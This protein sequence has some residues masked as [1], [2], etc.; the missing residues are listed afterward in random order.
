MPVTKTTFLISAILAATIAGSV[1]FALASSQP[2]SD[3]ALAP[4]DVVLTELPGLVP[5]DGEPMLAG[6]ADAAPEKGVVGRIPGPFDARFDLSNSSFD[7]DSVTGTVTVTSDVSDILELEVLAGFYDES[8]TL[9]GTATWVSPD[10]DHHE[11]A[12][13]T[14]D[15]PSGEAVAFAVEVPAELRADTVSAA[16]GVPVLVNE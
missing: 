4:G 14:P 8:G 5:A 2:A 12:D 15:G 1:A 13:A 11:A 16:V 6:I 10:T 9:L 7:G 3:V